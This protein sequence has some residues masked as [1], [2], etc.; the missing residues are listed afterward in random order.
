MYSFVPFKSLVC[1]LFVHSTFSAIQTRPS[2]RDSTR[3][4]QW[5]SFILVPR[6][7]VDQQQHNQQPQLFKAQNGIPSPDLDY[8]DASKQEDEREKRKYDA[9]TAFFGVLHNNIKPVTLLFE[10]NVRMPAFPA[11]IQPIS[12][13]VKI[14][15]FVAVIQT[16]PFARKTE[17]SASI[18]SPMPVV[19]GQTGTDDQVD[20][21]NGKDEQPKQNVMGQQQQQQMESETRNRLMNLHQGT[22]RDG[23]VKMGAG[24]PKTDTQIVDG[25][26]ERDNSRM[27]MQADEPLMM[28]PMALRFIN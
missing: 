12:S 3:E 22:K 16:V 1:I 24:K 18:K 28:P 2:G 8:Y 21:Q 17:Q 15:P 10:S 5:Q 11:I 25:S 27:Q 26:V 19:D 23:E 9:E 6:D 13:Q 14:D 20:G 4:N 7:H